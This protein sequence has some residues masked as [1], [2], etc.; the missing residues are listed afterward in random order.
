MSAADV[1]R[2][3]RE[4]GVELIPDGDHLRY[5]GPREVLTPDLLMEFKRHKPALI[6][7]IS[8]PPETYACSR[9]RR[10][11]FPQPVMCYWCRRLE[12]MGSEA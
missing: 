10:F 4:R 6:A 8:S 7:L 3:A 1:L 9:C 5:R 2:A 12:A 11:A